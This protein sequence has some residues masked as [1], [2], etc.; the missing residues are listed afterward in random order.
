MKDT[1][2]KT[3]ENL[4][5]VVLNEESSK[6]DSTNVVSFEE[7][8]KK[9]QKNKEVV[10]AIM[11]NKKVQEV[12]KIFGQERLERLFYEWLSNEEMINNLR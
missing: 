7:E 3:N 5:G 12:V 2:A 11:K 8:A 9:L 10:K 1:V 6:V 4:A